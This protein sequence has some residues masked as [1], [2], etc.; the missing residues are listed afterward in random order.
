MVR[1]QGGIRYIAVEEPETRGAEGYRREFEGEPGV[2]VRGGYVS[3]AVVPVE[4][5]AAT[6]CTGYHPSRLSITVGAVTFDLAEDRYAVTEDW[7]VG[8][9]TARTPVVDGCVAAGGMVAYEVA[10]RR[11]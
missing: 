1:Q 9:M 7:I 4:P 6:N 11:W 2:V 10:R 5:Q 8:V 3:D